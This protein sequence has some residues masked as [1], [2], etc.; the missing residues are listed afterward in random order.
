[1][2]HEQYYSAPFALFLQGTQPMRAFLR[3]LTLMSTLALLTAC[4]DSTEVE[5]NVNDNTDNNTAP[6][7][8]GPAP[9]TNEVQAFKIEFWDKLS[10]TNRCGQ[11]HTNGGPAASF[12]FVDLQDVNT[13]YTQATSRNSQGQLLVDRDNPSSSRVI[14]RVGEGHN[15]WEN[16][17]ND[18]CATIIEGYVNNWL[19][20]TTSSSSGRSIVL[21]P[22]TD[23]IAPGDSRNFPATS[24]DSNPNFATTIY[25]VLTANCSG[26][27]S[28]TSGTPQSPFFAGADVEAAYEAAKSKIDLD[29]LFIPADFSLQANLDKN[30]KSRFVSRILE[31]HNCWTASCTDDAEEMQTAIN[32]FA[33]GIV[34][35]AIDGALITSQAVTFNDAT[36]ASG[37][38]RY[39]NDQIALWEFKTGAGNE[40]FDSS[41]VEPAMKLTFSG[42]VS[43]ILGYGVN[44]S[45]GG[46]AQASTVTSKK[47][48]DLITLT[49]A[50]S[51]EA[52]VIPGN[53][54]QEDS[55]II[56]YSAGDTARNFSMSQTLYNYEFLNRS[57]NTDAEGRASLMTDPDD[58]DLQAALQHVVVTYDAV[59]G[60]RVYV[61]GVFTDD[62]DPAGTQGGTLLDWND[63]YA[64]VLGNEV[65]GSA[66]AWNGTLRMV[67][68]HNRAL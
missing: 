53:V 8:L 58:E 15:C 6:V 56:S 3:K 43:W 4:G 57:S 13:A 45:S 23:T 38:N 19:N 22:L 9:L 16:N 49:N 55:R 11:C 68:I 52:W 40:A 14:L 21:A 33:G 50:Y 46:K 7:Y 63:S 25:P 31:Q 37:G 67:A 24:Q 65:S 28:E 54:T 64:F 12:A 10:S 30:P 44:F 1:M 61:N 66:N 17:P 51:L 62:T 34:L 36:L 27:H 2:K 47:L 18:I 60:R 41:G 29:N 5:T 20:G 39:E 48:T 26:C 32:N 42:P 59:N 35:T